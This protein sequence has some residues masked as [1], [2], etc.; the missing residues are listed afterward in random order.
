MSEEELRRPRPALEQ[1][2]EHHPRPIA[3]TD[4]AAFVVSVNEAGPDSVYAYGLDGS[5]R[6]VPAPVDDMDLDPVWNRRLVPK[7]D[8]LG[9]LLLVGPRAA[10]VGALID[11]S[12][13][14]YGVLRSQY[15]KSADW[16]ET[17]APQFVDIYADSALVTY[18]PYEN[19]ATYIGGEIWAMKLHPIRRVSGEPCANMLPSV[20]PKAASNEDAAFENETGGCRPALYFATPASSQVGASRVRRPG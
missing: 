9:N 1:F 6:A 13:G 8:G 14:C 10:I 19:G 3:C 15:G 4:D 17:G 5:E 7:T 11:P 18:F 12:S 2:A 16:E 20:G